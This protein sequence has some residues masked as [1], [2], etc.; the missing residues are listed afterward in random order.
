MV[1]QLIFDIDYFLLN[2]KKLDQLLNI[3]QD[4]YQFK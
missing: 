1:N 4:I 3:Y 2:S